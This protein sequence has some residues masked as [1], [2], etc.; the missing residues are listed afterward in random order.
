MSAQARRGIDYENPIQDAI[1]IQ[2][3]LSPDVARQLAERDVSGVSVGASVPRDTLEHLA[4]I[5][6]L[7]R[8]DLSH[9]DDL[10]D[11]DLAFLEALP[12]LTAIS[13]AWCQRIGDKGIEF[14]RGHQHLE[15]V[16]LYWTC[17]G[18][19]AVAA[20]AGKRSLSRV[21]LGNRITDAGVARLHEF[22][23]LTV[24]GGLDSFLAISGGRTLT[25]QAL[26]FIGELKGVAALDVHTSVFGSPH[27]TARGVAHLKRLP[28]LEALN[29]HGQLATDDVLAEIAAIPCL[30][31][32]HCQDIVS[33][34]E[35]FIALGTCTTLENLGARFCSH[36][37]DRGLAPLARLPRLQTLGIGGPRL[38]DRAMAPFA[39][40]PALGDL[41]PML[42][43]DAAFAYIAKIPNL[44]KLTN[45]YNR[46]TTDAATRFL[47][48]H[49]RLMHYSAFG[50]QITDESL[51]ILAGLP[52]LEEL[53]F[54]NCA[55]ITDAGLREV[56]K[57]PRL[58]KVS[59]WSCVNVNGA[60][61]D[62]VP[63]GVEAKSDLGP[64]GQAEG[65][66]AE[67]LMDYPDLPI[68]DGRGPAGTPSTSGLLSELVD[69]G[70]HST[71]TGDGVRLS[72]EPGMDTRWIG[73]MTRDALSVPLR[74][75]IVARPISELRVRFGRHN[76]YFT[77]DEKGQFRDPAPW[78]LRTD[79]QQG[80]AHHS[81]AAQQIPADEWTRVALHIGEKQQQLFVNGEL[82]HSW[83][84]DF[85]GIRSRVGLGL[86]RSALDVS[87]LTVDRL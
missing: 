29:F 13:L 33:G 82:R 55:G 32:L 67:T 17:T 80:R 15:Q 34:D 69:F 61:L 43:G 66:V 76:R 19:E 60:W 14:L 87:T 57:L 7:R 68:R 2:G 64:P 37:T 8:L 47:R 36:V 46:A 22:P 45:M 41:A 52:A 75:E 10:V 27:Y 77:F 24:E 53:A 35:G 12:Q 26:A 48:N 25:D 84:G 78:F 59:A 40:A 1:P 79:A 85:A 54:E 74:I 21:V 44:K 56:A 28:A 83:D 38:S 65:Y 30:R 72:V 71:F 50:T 58:R 42:V 23:A 18:D 51:R 81:D 73:L 62:A 11:E 6:S 39:E 4:A 31:S 20:L 63:A 70:M 9:R 5:P 16:S 49:Q 86:V 3:A